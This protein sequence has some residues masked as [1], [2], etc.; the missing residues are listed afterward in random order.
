MAQLLEKYNFGDKFMYID[1]KAVKKLSDIA[2]LP[3]QGQRTTFTV[4]IPDSLQK[5]IKSAKFPAD[6]YLLVAT[7]TITSY[8]NAQLTWGTSPDVKDAFTWMLVNGEKMS[9]QP[10]IA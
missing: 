10:I 8:H 6:A 1:L 9:L 7:E 5:E 2:T 4:R 3:F